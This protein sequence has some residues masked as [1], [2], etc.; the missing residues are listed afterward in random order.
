MAVPVGT[1]DLKVTE[2]RALSTLCSLCGTFGSER[3]RRSE[4]LGEL[5]PAHTNL[6]GLIASMEGDNASQKLRKATLARVQTELDD[7]ERRRNQ[8]SFEQLRLREELGM[9][10][11]HP[12]RDRFEKETRAVALQGT[13]DVR[14]EPSVP[15]SDTHV[16]PPR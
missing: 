13:T 7:V 2:P 12:D 6:F 9:L 11:G 16:V 1:I 8:L 14:T 15:L 4:V 5:W 3:A 10:E